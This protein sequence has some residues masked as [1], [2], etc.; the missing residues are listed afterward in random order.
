MQRC[1]VCHARL[2]ER[3]VCSRCKAD[4]SVLI[5]SERAAQYWLATAIHDY[6]SG[7]T[8]QSINAMSVSLRLHKINLALALR[9]FLIQQQCR[10]ILDLLAQKQL[11]Q[12]KKSLYRVR[13]LLPY[14]KCLQQLSAFSEYLV[15][16]EIERL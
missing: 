1:P 6:L 14:S 9:D 11:L 5:S 8:E 16:A 2:R 7:K 15:C 4:L 13:T 10:D 12:A 3:K